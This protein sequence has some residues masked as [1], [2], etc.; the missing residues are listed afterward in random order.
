MIESMMKTRQ[1]SGLSSE[2]SF[3][4]TRDGEAAN[5]GRKF[6]RLKLL[7]DRVGHRLITVW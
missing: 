7:E 6:E 1:S 5:I 4:I 2:M 3:G